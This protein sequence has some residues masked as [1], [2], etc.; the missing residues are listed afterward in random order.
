MFNNSKVSVGKSR[1][2]AIQSY[3]DGKI[4]RAQITLDYTPYKSNKVWKIVAE[5]P[6]T[7]DSKENLGQMFDYMFRNRVLDT[8]LIGL[9]SFLPIIDTVKHALG[10]NVIHIT[11]SSVHKLKEFMPSKPAA[12]SLS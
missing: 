10:F 3:R 7:S 5:L 9:G 2:T 12:V 8:E 4:C 6:A 11:W 1:V